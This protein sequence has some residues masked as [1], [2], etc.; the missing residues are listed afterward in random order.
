MLTADM[1]VAGGGVGAAVDLDL[2]PDM[3]EHCCQGRGVALDEPQVGSSPA[4]PQRIRACSPRTAT[5]DHSGQSTAAQIGRGLSPSL[6]R[7]QTSPSVVDDPSSCDGLARCASAACLTESSRWSRSSSTTCPSGI[8][9]PCRHHN[10][11]AGRRCWT[12][13]AADLAA[14]A[15]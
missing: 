2:L 10:P 3:V 6:L 5:R 15:L 7:K 14:Q 4:L 9:E 11:S 13:D 8:A 1:T 12:R